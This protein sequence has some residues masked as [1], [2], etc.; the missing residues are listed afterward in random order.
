MKDLIWCLIPGLE[1]LDQTL[2]PLNMLLLMRLLTES[3]TI[4]CK[5]QTYN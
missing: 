1:I 3:G 5:D 4:Q 2:S